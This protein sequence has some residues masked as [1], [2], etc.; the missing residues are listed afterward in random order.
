MRHGE[1][2]ANTLGVIACGTESISQYGLTD[3]GIEQARQSAEE[4]KRNYG[5]AVVYSSD[6]SRALET[7]TILA[8]TIG[9]EVNI[10]VRLRERDF[11]EFN[12]ASVSEYGKIWEI[13][14]IEPDAKPYGV[15]SINEVVLRLEK[16][17]EKSETQYTHQNIV[18]VGHGDP[19]L[20]WEIYSKGLSFS[21]TV[22]YI[23]NAEIRPLVTN[24]I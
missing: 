4:F 23:G 21:E 2:E 14:D 11:G 18:L 22:H 16:L 12:G 8:E 24:E 19:L 17:V 15:E 7:A 9:V 13:T 10:D 1:S 5:T 3:L 6:Y 20:I